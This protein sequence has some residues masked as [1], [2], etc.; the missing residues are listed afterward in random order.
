MSLGFLLRKFVFL[1][2]QD[3]ETVNSLIKDE[4]SYFPLGHIYFEA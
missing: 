4:Y 2:I 1:N 3:L